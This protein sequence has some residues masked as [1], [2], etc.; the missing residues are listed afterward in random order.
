M[1]SYVIIGLNTVLREIC[2]FLINKIGYKTETKRLTE[3]T[4]LT[5]AVQFLNTAILPLL[6]NANF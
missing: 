6:A 1:M 5:F 4:K 3:I 2:I